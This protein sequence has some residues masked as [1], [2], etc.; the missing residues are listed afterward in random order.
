[1]QAGGKNILYIFA[2]SQTHELRNELFH[3]P[4]QCP[5]TV[6]AISISRIMRIEKSAVRHAGSG[7]GYF[8]IDSALRLRRR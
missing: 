6:R 4:V 2:F 1:M 3:V 8:I 5:Y 7:V